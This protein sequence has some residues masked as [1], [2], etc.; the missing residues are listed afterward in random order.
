MGIV[1]KLHRTHSTTPMYD[2]MSHG[3]HLNIDPCSIEG[4]HVGNQ[5]SDGLP[6]WHHNYTTSELLSAFMSPDS[7]S[8]IKVRISCCKTFI[9]D[10]FVSAFFFFF[11]LTEHCLFLIM[12]AWDCSSSHFTDDATAASCGVCDTKLPANAF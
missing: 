10:V 4:C 2:P 5:S 3:T 1:N 12:L 6:S 8:P 9:K 7:F 11:L